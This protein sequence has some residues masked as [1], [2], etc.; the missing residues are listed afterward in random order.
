MHV[1][2]DTISG[3][4]GSLP[5]FKELTDLDLIWVVE[6]DLA[7]EEGH[8]RLRADGVTVRNRDPL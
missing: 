7:Q 2:V 3:E 1:I 6:S 5:V 4:I 8:R